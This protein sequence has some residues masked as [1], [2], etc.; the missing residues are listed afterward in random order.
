MKYSLLPF[1]TLRTVNKDLQSK[2][3]RLLIQAGYIHQEMAGVYT[4]L[5][6][7]L[8]VLNKIE[9]IIREEMDKIGVEIF[10]SSLSPIENWEKSKRFD[11]VDV[12]MKTTPA[13]EKAKEKHNAEYILSPTHEDMVTP[14]VKEFAR[15]YK[16]FPIAVYQIQTKFRN[17]PRA[18]SGL[19]RCREFRM[20]DLYS[21]HT[22][23]G[24]LKKYYEESK[25]A[26]WN[27]FERLGIG[28]H[29]TYLTLASGGDFTPDYSH[30]FQTVCDA[31]EDIIFHVKSKNLTY[32]REVAPSKAP[33]L[34]NNEKMMP[35]KD[36]KGEG[37]IGVDD[38]SKHLG[39]PVERTIKTLIFETDKGEVIIAAVRGDYDVHEE[40][41]KKVVGCN[42]LQL[43]SPEVVKKTTGAE[44]GYAGIINLP[45][46]VKVYLDDAIGP[47]K[48]FETGT[49][50]TNY[51]TINVN[52]D[53]D[54]KRP[55][56]FY[57][58]KVAKTGD[59]YPETDE[60]YEVIKA[61][62]VG[63]I[64]PLN[65]K[66]SQA[67]G[68]YYT[69][70][71]GKEK[72][73]YMGSYGIGPS[74]VLGVLVEKFADEKG[75]VWPDNVAPFQ[76][77][78]ISLK[79]NEKAEKIYRQLQQDGIEVFYDDREV[80]AGQKFADAELLGIPV[81][82]VISQKTGDKIEWKRRTEGKREL[83]SL[84]EVLKKLSS[85]RG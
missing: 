38:L 71:T 51:H 30:E 64:F 26:Y 74:R 57:D 32:N 50:K 84:K 60:P 68:Y 73:V 22:S 24:E 1:K 12:L 37:V 39:V 8:R 44:I 47:M 20:K 23:E 9:N 54:V 59:H 18:K 31:G 48:N 45:K 83:L 52:F 80:S 61:A 40:K 19:L 70:D 55:N 69:D 15:S 75:L 3:A 2:N 21:F 77:Y 78:L 10:M 7:G 85:V 27:V 25:D 4:F 49:N 46:T 41:L 56:K 58:I 67:F 79:E 66:F 13:N 62:E 14:L 43:A 28:R 6:L 72:P 34:K 53:R 5:P 16:D 81:R 42:N 63:N 36:I 82:L 65:T 35:M 33:Q 29:T 76:V 17:E 11:S